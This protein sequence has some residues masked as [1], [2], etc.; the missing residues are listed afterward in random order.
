MNIFSVTLFIW[1]LSFVSTQPEGASGCNDEVSIV[2]NKVET[3]RIDFV[4]VEG[5]ALKLF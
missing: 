4:L 2:M 3:G 1:R 5:T